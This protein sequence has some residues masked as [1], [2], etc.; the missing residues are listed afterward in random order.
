[1]MCSAQ[2]RKLDM[3]G[4]LSNPKL[5]EVE[6]CTGPDVSPEAG[7]R[8]SPRARLSLIRHSPYRTRA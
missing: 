1:M 2:N 5:K 8:L 4:S 6:V 3:I 7:A